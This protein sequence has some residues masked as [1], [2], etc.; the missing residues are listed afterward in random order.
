MQKLA[1]PGS[2]RSDRHHLQFVPPAIVLWPQ[3]GAV[4]ATHV[5]LHHLGLLGL[6][7]IGSLVAAFQHP[8]IQIFARRHLRYHSSLFGGAHVAR[9]IFDRARGLGGVLAMETRPELGLLLD[10]LVPLHHE[11]PRILEAWKV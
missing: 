2:Q 3:S 10:E 9:R 7:C 11:I 5:H 1:A 4:L 6:G 8:Q